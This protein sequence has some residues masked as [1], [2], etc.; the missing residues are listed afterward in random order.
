M[1]SW[2]PRLSSS[3][4]AN[5]CPTSPLLQPPCS[6]SMSMV[7]RLR[8]QS[9]PTPC[10]GYLSVCLEWVLY[11][12]STV[13]QRHGGMPAQLRRAPPRGGH[14]RRALQRAPPRPRTW[15][16][17]RLRA[18][19]ACGPPRQPGRPPPPAAAPRLRRCGTAV[20]TCCLWRRHATTGWH[21]T[22]SVSCQFRCVAMENPLNAQC[23][24]SREAPPA[25]VALG[26]ASQ[27]S[28]WP[29][30]LWRRRR[31]CPSSV[32]VASVACLSRWSSSPAAPGE[33]QSEDRGGDATYMLTDVSGSM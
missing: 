24:L 4:I 5:L 13:N 28:M 32:T 12:L 23:I 11:G 6:I 19:P 15:P 20:T 10:C 22:C 21:P 9:L 3:S 25:S 30:R 27:Y 26:R 2:R 14:R 33:Q 16:P 7:L 31:R 8:R 18:P 1:P 29:S 17:P